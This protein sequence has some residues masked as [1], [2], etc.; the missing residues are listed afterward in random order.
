MAD[1]Y[2]KRFSTSPSIRKGHGDGKSPHIHVK[3]KQQIL[4]GLRKLE[5][6]CTSGAHAFGTATAENSMEGAQ[7]LKCNYDRT[8]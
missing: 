5:S 4:I 6:S 7:K 3:Q 8:R 2:M 1:R